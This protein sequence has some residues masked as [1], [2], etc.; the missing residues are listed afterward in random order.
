MTGAKQIFEVRKA[1]QQNLVVE[2]GV[3]DRA[4]AI[5]AIAPSMPKRAEF[6]RR[7]R[8]RYKHASV[9]ERPPQSFGH[10]PEL[11]E[12]PPPRGLTSHC[13]NEAVKAIYAYSAPLYMCRVVLFLLRQRRGAGL[14][15]LQRARGRS[16]YFAI[17]PVHTK[18]AL[19]GALRSRGRS[20]KT[21]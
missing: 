18:R 17:A 9:V 10:R 8:Q 12:G 4:G 19:Y 5:H 14:G 21:T 3:A 1:I 16:K 6:F 13:A 11:A 15:E 7:R 2:R 20:G